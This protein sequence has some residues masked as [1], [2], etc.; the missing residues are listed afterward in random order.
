[1]IPGSDMTPEA[2]LMK[3]SFVLGRHDWTHEEK[4]KVRITNIS[5]IQNNNRQVKITLS[6]IQS[7]EKQVKITSKC[8]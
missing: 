2:A 1:M 7:N 5:K 6:K 8:M 3:L 4:K